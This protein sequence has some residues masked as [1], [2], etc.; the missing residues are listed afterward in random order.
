MKLNPEMD[1][2]ALNRKEVNFKRVRHMTEG[3]WNNSDM[4]SAVKIALD[5]TEVNNRDVEFS[6]AVNNV[7]R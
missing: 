2:N 1:E 7:A 5:V 4:E 6:L 3:E